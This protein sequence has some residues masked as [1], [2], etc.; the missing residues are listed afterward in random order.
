MGAPRGKRCR[1]VGCGAIG[2][3]SL[4]FGRFEPESR[5]AVQGALDALD[6]RVC[7]EHAA[8][9]GKVGV[10]FVLLDDP[11]KVAGWR[12]VCELVTAPHAD[13]IVLYPPARA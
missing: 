11:E 12:L 2:A 7:G 9:L 4:V 3:H 5:V 13:P 1:V 10:E 8:Q 6:V